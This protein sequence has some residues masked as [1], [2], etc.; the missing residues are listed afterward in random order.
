VT[1]ERHPVGRLEA[2]VAGQDAKGTTKF[3]EPECQFAGRRGAR[4]ELLVRGLSCL[5]FTQSP[6]SRPFPKS[7]A[8]KPD[9]PQSFFARVNIDITT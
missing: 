1:D 5:V 6:R 8:R 3:A 4:V 7:G 2:L 9:E